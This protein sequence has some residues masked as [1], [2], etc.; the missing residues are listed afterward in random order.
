M[1]FSPLLCNK[2]NTFFPLWAARGFFA[3]NSSLPAGWIDRWRDWLRAAH[4]AASASTQNTSKHERREVREAPPGVTNLDCGS[5]YSIF[6]R[7]FYSM[8]HH[9]ITSNTC[10]NANQYSFIT[11]K[12][13][14]LHRK[15]KVEKHYH[16]PSLLICFRTHAPQNF[17]STNHIQNLN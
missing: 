9:G 7:S 10:G 2:R 6:T 17:K 3:L 15:L 11:V 16:W 13:F 14:F 12:Y 8:Q 4:R 5:F 1:E